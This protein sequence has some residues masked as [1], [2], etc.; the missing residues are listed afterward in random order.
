MCYCWP[1]RLRVP[2]LN[3]DLHPPRNGAPP[4]RPH[5]YGT[6]L[7]SKTPSGTDHRGQHGVSKVIGRHYSHKG[8]TSNLLV[9]W[10]PY[11]LKLLILKW[12]LGST[13]LPN[14]WAVVRSLLISWRE[15]QSTFTSL[16]QEVTLSLSFTQILPDLQYLCTQSGS[17]KD[18]NV[19]ILSVFCF[20]TVGLL[21]CLI[22]V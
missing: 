15:T 20:L 8:A 4:G 1:H 17:N 21:V 19:S 14:T 7:Q 6:D 13:R 11:L 2:S 10:K 18:T 16:P 5:Q 22:D 3:S 9:L 12:D